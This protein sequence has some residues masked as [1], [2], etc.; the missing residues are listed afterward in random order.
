MKHHN[1]VT[2]LRTGFQPSLLQKT[3][4]KFIFYSILYS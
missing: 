4:L 1:H 2:V 3:S